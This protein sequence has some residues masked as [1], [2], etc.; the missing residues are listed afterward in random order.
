MFWAE[1]AH[2]A[3]EPPSLLW[4]HGFFT[5]KTVVL[6]IPETYSKKSR[7]WVDH[8]LHTVPW[9]HRAFHGCMRAL[10]TLYP[11]SQKCIQKPAPLWV[12]H[13]LHTML[14]S[15]QALRGSMGSPRSRCCTRRSSNAFFKSQRKTIHPHVTNA[16]VAY[17]CASTMKCVTFCLG[18]H[19][20]V[21]FLMNS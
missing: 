15:Y 12:H 4:L 7:L 21:I 9:S 1:T 8:T 13:K 14:W 3:L 2:N 18:S 5:L 19:A 6:D 17:P 20:G 10:K 16:L 11:T